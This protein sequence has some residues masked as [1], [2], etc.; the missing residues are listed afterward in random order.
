MMKVSRGETV[1]RLALSLRLPS[2]G[3][4][5]AGRGDEEASFGRL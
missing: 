4:Q 5:Q 2:E 1:E 3:A